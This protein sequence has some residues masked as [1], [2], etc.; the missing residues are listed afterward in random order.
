[1]DTNLDSRLLEDL[2]Q[3]Q[4][5][6]IH[7]STESISIHTTKVRQHDVPSD[8]GNNGEGARCIKLISYV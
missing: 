7:N 5:S 8:W 6:I 4:S 3:L 2:L 1:M